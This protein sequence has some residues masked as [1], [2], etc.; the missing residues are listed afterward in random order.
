MSCKE[1]QRILL[2]AEQSDPD[3]EILRHLQRC[4]DCRSA[5]TVINELR[6]IPA[7]KTPERL[8]ESTLN[9]SRGAFQYVRSRQ[10]SKG[11]RSW[12][13]RIA[14]LWRSPRLVLYLGSFF[15]VLLFALIGQASARPGAPDWPFAMAMLIVL[16]NLSAALFA[17]LL[18]ASRRQPAPRN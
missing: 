15:L 10:Y 16:Q 18:L 6:R 11:R 8:S 2:D 12:K 7:G 14:E 17:P 9:L 5:W 13:L 3:G 4:P 1:T